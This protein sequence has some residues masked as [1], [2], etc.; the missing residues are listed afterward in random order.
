MIGRYPSGG[1][2]A[3]ALRSLRFPVAPPRT[4][5]RTRCG[6]TPERLGVRS[7]E[8]APLWGFFQE[9]GERDVSRTS[10]GPERAAA[11]SQPHLCSD[12]SGSVSRQTDPFA[13]AIRLLV[14]LPGHFNPPPYDAFAL[15]AAAAPARS[16]RVARADVRL[17]KARFIE[18]DTGG[19][20]YSLSVQWDNVCYNSKI[21]EQPVAPIFL[22]GG[23]PCHSSHKNLALFR[24]KPLVSPMPLTRG[25]ARIPV[26]IGQSIQEQRQHRVLEVALKDEHTTPGPGC[27]H[28]GS[29]HPEAAGTTHP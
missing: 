7:I 14:G 20:L 15:A 10:L 18:S 23:S 27:A 25:H 24:K 11:G 28:L 3:A 4:V 6:V 1:V 9:V 19:E 16:E 12:K 2:T 13:N 8:V 26:I 22:A 17:A 5:A 21:S 29:G